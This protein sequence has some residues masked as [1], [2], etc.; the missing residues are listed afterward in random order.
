[1][2]LLNKKIKDKIKLLDDIDKQYLIPTKTKTQKKIFSKNKN[3]YNMHTNSTEDIKN[4]KNENFDKV[5]SDFLINGNLLDRNRN[6]NNN[7]R[8]KEKN[9]ELI[10]SISNGSNKIKNKKE[11][12][13]NN[14]AE[15][16]NNY[17]KFIKNKKEI[18]RKIDNIKTRKANSINESR[19]RNKKDNMEPKINQEQNNKKNLSN[20]NKQKS[21]SK[22]Y[23][24]IMNN[25]FTYHPKLNRKSLQLAKK[26]EPSFIRL[27]KKKKGTN[28]E[29]VKLNTFYSNLYK[30][31]ETNT[32]NTN[33]H[34]DK[35]GSK[36]KYSKNKTIYEK[37]NKLYLR[38]LEHKEKI[39][40]I[41]SE[42]KKKKEEDYK[43][44]TFKPK[45]NKII[46]YFSAKNH[47]KKNLS[48]IIN[49]KRNSKREIKTDNIYEKN[50]AWKKN[51]EKLNL[52]R[53]IEYEENISKLYT[54]HPQ[55]SDNK[56]PAK[57][58]SKY[59]N[60]VMEQINDYVSKRRQN[61]KYKKS[62]EKY[63][64]KKFFV[65]EGGY[66][67]RTTIPKEFE[68][69]TEIRQRSFGK[70]KNRSCQNF[71]INQ[72]RIK[73]EQSSGKKSFGE[74]ERLSWFYKEEVNNKNCGYNNENNITKETYS[75]SQVDFIEAVNLLH[76]KLDKLN[77]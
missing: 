21:S 26:M 55:I 59:I 49:K 51:L 47:S 25:N 22:K 40:K 32:T 69:E 34:N 37:M 3:E 42:N 29:E 28:N 36:S 43:K 38:G 60:K 5:Y 18:E 72:N 24:T 35:K 1:M 7:K 6:N 45:I 50:F 66:T 53:K 46:P 48:L 44:Y 10:F 74:N 12:K 71:H 17:G 77:I 67:P 16:L 76:D 54:F 68:F 33:N 9:D 11:T 73:K 13:D 19:T 20:N 64:K 70:N 39:E 57:T 23:L 52:K 62:E 41:Y 75:H 2:N 27:N 30:Y 15:R 4:T 14:V 63:K 31:K 58:D 61:I 65:P 56:S 8:S